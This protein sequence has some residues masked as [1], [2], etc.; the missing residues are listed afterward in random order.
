[1]EGITPNFMLPLKVKD[2]DIYIPP[3]KGKP[4]QQQFTIQSHLLP[5]L[6]VE[7]AAQQAAAHS[8]NEQ[9]FIAQLNTPIYDPAS[10]TMALTPQC[11]PA[12][13]S[14]LVLQ[15]S[16]LVL[17]VPLFYSIATFQQQDEDIL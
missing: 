4:D 13:N 11:S 17:I 15:Y 12:N 9:T 7:G 1:M 16:T 6:A 3:L 14:L 10:C 2:Q 5:A 8:P